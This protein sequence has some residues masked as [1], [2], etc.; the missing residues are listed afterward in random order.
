MNLV[1]SNAHSSEV[2]GSLHLYGHGR[3]YWYELNMDNV[4]KKSDMDMNGHAQ[5]SYE[6]GQQTNDLLFWADC[7]DA[8]TGHIQIVKIKNE[9]WFMI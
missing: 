8:P 3:K 4:Q 9:F 7:I 5:R 2:S 6:H 1:N